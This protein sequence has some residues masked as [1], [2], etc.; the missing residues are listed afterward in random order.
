MNRE[1]TSEK[2]KQTTRGTQLRRKTAEIALA[3]RGGF[4]MWQAI[5]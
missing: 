3:E 5:M 2:V 1:A 4:A